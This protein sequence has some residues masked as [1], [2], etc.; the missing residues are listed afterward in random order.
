MTHGA[1]SERR[2]LPLAEAHVAALLADPA[3]PGY[4]R[5]PSFSRSLLAF[6][7]A[8]A[9]VD[10]LA[11]WLNGQDLAEALSELTKTVESEEGSRGDMRRKLVSRRTASVAE[12]LA[13][14]EKLAAH[15]RA[16]LGL[17]PRSRMAIVR[18]AGVAAQAVGEA[19]ESLAE[20]GRV[21][22]ERRSAELQAGRGGSEGVSGQGA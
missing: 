12:Q 6:G 4:L 14:A 15:L 3:S 17:A 20:K 19:V 10:L 2:L 5:D 11:G 1:Y 18:D 22:R 21:I 8:E 9:M 7:R 16:E 13:K